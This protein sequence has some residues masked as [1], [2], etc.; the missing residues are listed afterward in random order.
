MPALQATETASVRFDVL[1]LEFDSWTNPAESA[2]YPTSSCWCVADPSGD[3][4]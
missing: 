2:L 4:E 3:S 1:I